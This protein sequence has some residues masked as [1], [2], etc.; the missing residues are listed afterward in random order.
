MTRPSGPSSKK[1]KGHAF[2]KDLETGEDIYYNDNAGTERR[3]DI[4]TGEVRWYGPGG[5]LLRGALMSG[6]ATLDAAN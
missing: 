3:R 6:D 4:R 5:Q 2:E 1:G